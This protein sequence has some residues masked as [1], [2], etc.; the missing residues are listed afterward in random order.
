MGY[1]TKGERATTAKLKNEQVL[2]IYHSKGITE[3][4]LA[5][6]YG[7]TRSCISNIRLGYTWSH[8][9]KEGK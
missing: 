3:K 2:E 1:N 8:I 5:E 4:K 7:V 6:K 9:T